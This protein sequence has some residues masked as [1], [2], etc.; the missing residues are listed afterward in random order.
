MKPTFKFC[1]TIPVLNGGIIFKENL[2]QIKKVAYLFDKIYISITSPETYP[3]DIDSCN[4]CKIENLVILK[5]NQKSLVNN[6]IFLF[7]HISQSYIFVLGHDDAPIKN[8]IIEIKE[9]IKNSKSHPVSSFGSNIWTNNNKS[10]NNNHFK[11]IESGKTYQS[12]N[13]FIQ[14]R[15]KEE[16]PLNQSGMIFHSSEVNSYKSLLSTN[17]NSYWLDMMLITTPGVSKIYESSN[18]V[19]MVG[20]HPNQLSINVPDFNEYVYSGMWYHFA[21]SCYADCYSFWKSTINHYESLSSYI[22]LKLSIKYTSKLIFIS[23]TKWEKI[24]SFKFTFF[25]I[26]ILFFKLTLNIIKFSV[27]NIRINLNKN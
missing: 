19:S 1:L 6:F 8:G 13:D 11:L 10:K 7:N 25:S 18:P 21:Q 2:N 12:K 26:T 20:T 14:R 3:M 23:I 5:F 17:I 16:F 15:I 24:F 27:N 4:N 22:D 9:I